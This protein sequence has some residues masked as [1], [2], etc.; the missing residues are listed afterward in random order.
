M[1]LICEE[2]L[3]HSEYCIEC[4]HRFEHDYHRGCNLECTK[5]Y[6]NTKCI[7]VRQLKLKKLNS[8]TEK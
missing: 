8:L 3:T 1:K 2:Q 6:R 7:T 4:S 5:L